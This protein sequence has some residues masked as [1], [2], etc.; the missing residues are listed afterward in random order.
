MMLLQCSGRPASDACH[1]PSVSMCTNNSRHRGG[2]NADVTE[3]AGSVWC[4]CGTG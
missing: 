2:P 4:V 1:C 3:A